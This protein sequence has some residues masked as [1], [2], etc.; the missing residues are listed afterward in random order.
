MEKSMMSKKNFQSI[1]LE[2]PLLTFGDGKKYI[3]PKMGLMAYGPCLYKDR[4]IISSTIR[5]GLI[6][7][8]DSIELAKNW[9][10]KCKKVIPGK[11]E[12]PNMYPNFLGFTRIFGSDI[13][14]VDE[15]IEELDKEEIELCTSHPRYNNRVNNAA[16]LIISKLQNLRTREP[17][18]HV[19]I[20]ALPQKIIDLC[21]KRTLEQ[22]RAGIKLTEREKEILKTINK[23]R[24]TGQTV[25]V[26]LT[27]DILDL[28]YET[29]DLRC[30]IKA[31]AM[32][33]GMPTQL[34]KPSTFGFEAPGE[35]VQHESI[36]A[37]NFCTG[38][39]YKAEGY[40]WKLAEMPIGTCYVGISFYRV[41]KLSGGYI[42]A[43]LAQIFTH[44]GEGLVLKGSRTIRDRITKIPHLTKNASYQLLHNSLE[45]YKSQ[46]GEYPKRLVLHKSTR[47]WSVE[48]EGFKEATKNIESTDFISIQTRGIK[49][50]R[51]R[52][53]YPP[54][55]GTVIK[56]S[57]KNYILF[58]KGWIELYE[59]YPG[60][61]VPTPLE[62]TEHIGES[63][64]DTIC[65]EI[66][67]LTKMNWNSA[68]FCIREP[69]TLAYSRQVGK[70]LAYL[71]E[72]IRPRP[73]YLYYM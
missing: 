23:Q 44:T 54:R 60:L 36:R 46:M 50:M 1:F 14:I 52:G 45:L 72:E 51:R 10:L 18:P 66:L 42:R 37:W 12:N 43:S 69:V 63:S 38:L 58:T 6:G 15:C 35:S 32:V 65:E 21:G 55:R 2:E 19:T 71:P 4:N 20:I 16:K 3:D 33:F 25:L 73:E 22:Y 7:S 34:A 17:R 11:S 57:N 5:L 49:F 53:K 24:R 47:F 41:P 70:I 27:D 61:R 40:P 64:I 26:P 13:R 68:D 31:N 30:L 28:D 62:V 48:L 59:T 56:L 9:I 39:Y 67:A 8:K 29:T